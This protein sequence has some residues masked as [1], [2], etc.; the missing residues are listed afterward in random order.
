MGG[1]IHPANGATQVYSSEAGAIGRHATAKTA[2]TPGLR[3]AEVKPTKKSAANNSKGRRCNVRLFFLHF[4]Q[5][6]HDAKA[7]QHADEREEEDAGVAEQA[8]DGAGD[9]T[10]KKE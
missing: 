8:D 9:G 1:R 6:Q 2:Q 3:L 4:A 10:D 5:H 7:G